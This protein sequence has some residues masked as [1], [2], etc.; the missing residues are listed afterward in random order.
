MEIGGDGADAEHENE[1]VERVERPAEKT[2]DEGVALLLG[3][4][5]EVVEELDGDE[6]LEG[7]AIWQGRAVKWCP[8]PLGSSG[9]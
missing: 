5:A 9:V 7:G 2:R 1:E 4:R 3:E 8:V 6:E